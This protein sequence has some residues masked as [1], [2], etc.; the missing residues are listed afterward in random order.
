MKP[1]YLD[2]AATTPLDGDVREAMRPFLS[3]TFGN[4][5]S[6][7]AFGRAARRALDC[8]R[9]QVADLLGAEPD[10]IVFTSG[11][12]EAN[13]LAIRGS[14][15]TPAGATLATTTIEHQSALVPFQG[16]EDHGARVLRL[17][18]DASATLDP[19]AAAA[20]LPPETTFV[21]V[22]LA[23][24]DVG[25]IQPVQAFAEALRGRSVTLHSDAVQAVGKVPIQVR[26][27]GVD[28]LSLSAHKIYGPKGVG[29]LYVR[30]GTALA[31]SALGGHQEAGRRGGTENLPGIVGFGKA[32]EL[33][34][35]RMDEDA[36]GVSALRDRFEA[37]VMERIEGVSVNGARG[38][39]LPGT[40]NLS[41][42]GVDGEELTM[43]LDLCGV[44]AATS[45]ACSSDDHEPS[46]VLQAMGL[47]AERVSGA[48]RFSLGRGTDQGDVEAAV[49]AIV[50]TVARLR[51]SRIR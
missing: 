33:A 2:H 12:T 20:M 7:H 51:R 5:S 11:G 9:A 48:V 49:V 26:R 50:D 23:N 32:C 6:L 18:V 10:E 41:F 34:A 37:A 45:S 22:M 13:N 16:L 1:I 30:R 4:P 46:H 36:R 28:L 31:A 29:A 25:T 40:T 43:M 47:S 15:P 8:A 27:L 42:E 44:A 19:E 24:N 39:R 14:V 3:E 17:P 38:R 21:S 35:S